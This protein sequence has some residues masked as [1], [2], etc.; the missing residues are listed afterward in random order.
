MLAFYHFAY[1]GQSHNPA[2]DPQVLNPS[3]TAL[4]VPIPVKSIRRISRPICGHSLTS[5]RARRSITSTPR[6]PTVR[7]NPLAAREKDGRKLIEDKELLGVMH[8]VKG[9]ERFLMKTDSKT[10]TFIKAHRLSEIQ[11]LHETA[12]KLCSD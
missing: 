2:D 8:A 5:W 3:D 7:Q 11:S 1:P 6:F 12:A 9:I 4:E 10:L